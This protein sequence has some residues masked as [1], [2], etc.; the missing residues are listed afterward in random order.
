M[1]ST[2]R[3]MVQLDSAWLRLTLLNS[4]WLILTQIDLIELLYFWI[5]SVASVWKL[6]SLLQKNRR[7]YQIFRIL[8]WITF[9]I[10]TFLKEVAEK[11]SLTSNFRIKNWLVVVMSFSTKRRRPTNQN[12]QIFDRFSSQNEHYCNFVWQKNFW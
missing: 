2:F 6:L 7:K 10:I 5:E 9:N 1:W 12:K 4:A 8:C 3:N 11:S